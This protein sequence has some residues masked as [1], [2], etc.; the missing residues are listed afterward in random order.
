LYCKPAH[1]INS[2]GVQFNVRTHPVPEERTLE[3]EIKPSVEELKKRHPTAKLIESGETTLAGLPAHRLS[4]DC[5]YWGLPHKGIQIRTGQKGRV[6]ALEYLAT[7]EEYPKHV[8]KARV[9]FES[10][11]ILTPPPPKAPSSKL[12]RFRELAEAWARTSEEQVDEREISKKV[13]QLSDRFKP[14]GRNY[15]GLSWFNDACL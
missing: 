7:K 8:G 11:E 12:Q 2:F 14:G 9:M 3:Q 15:H 6:Y 13:Q 1:Y 4:F 10:F 5:E